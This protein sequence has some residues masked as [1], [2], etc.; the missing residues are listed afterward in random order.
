MDFF[1]LEVNYL[2]RIKTVDSCKT[3]DWQNPY[4][5]TLHTFLPLL[6]CEWARPELDQRPGGEGKETLA[7]LLY[8]E[9]GVE[10]GWRIS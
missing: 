1:F 3:Y 8:G 6:N 2:P 7:I 10:G 5:H 4:L 9:V